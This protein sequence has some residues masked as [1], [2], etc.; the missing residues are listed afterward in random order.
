MGRFK[1]KPIRRVE[2][3]VGDPGLSPVEPL[4][5]NSIGQTQPDSSPMEF[6]EIIAGTDPNLGEL[7]LC[8]ARSAVSSLY[9]KLS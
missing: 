7:S 5:P 6:L 3:E 1:P 4:L 9:A 8:R 2:E